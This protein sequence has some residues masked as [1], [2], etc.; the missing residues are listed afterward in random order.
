LL[1][2]DDNAQFYMA[3]A[4]WNFTSQNTPSENAKVKCSEFSTLSQ[5]IKMQLKCI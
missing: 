2:S 5:Q 3:N 1:V 4:T